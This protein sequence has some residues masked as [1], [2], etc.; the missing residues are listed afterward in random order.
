MTPR[1][2]V[3]LPT[4]NRAS[5][6]EGAVA[7][8]LASDL[9]LE[10]IVLDN[11]S[12]DGTW[13]FLQDLAR[14]DRRLRPI[15]WDGNN[16]YEAYAWPL[17]QARG[18]FVN[19]FADDDEMLP[20]G[21]AR[22]LELLER[23]PDLGMVFSTVACMDV[24]GKDLGEGAWTRIGPE[25]ALDRRDLFQS[26]VLGNFVAMPTAMF[27]RSLAPGADLFRDRSFFASNDW[28]FWLD[29]VQRTRVA[30]LSAPTARL[31]LH[32]G[33][34]TITHGIN[35]GHFME[36][37]LRVWRYWMLEHDPPFI[38]TAGTW[39]AMCRIM[40]GAMQASLGQDQDRI[41]AGFRRLQALRDEQD[42][43]L[44][45]AQ[46]LQEAGQAEAF[47][48][49]PDWLAGDWQGVVK[50]YLEAFTPE[51]PVALFLVLDP[52]AAGAPEEDQAGRALA[53]V[54]AEAG[55]DW[56]PEVRVVGPDR[57]FEAVRAFPHLQWLRRRTLEGVKGKRLSACLPGRVQ[58]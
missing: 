27:R 8:V 44:G 9:D 53:Q 2:S 17:E 41:Q 54:V 39:S 3:L 50:G 23:T 58:P 32:A 21:L 28:Q 34:V 5:M 18:E 14:R 36:A 7:S 11:G 46:D 49:E 51:D 12:Q 6:L 35:Q 4:F 19:F 56:V 15:H 57:V 22:K 38:P 31:R 25:D 45:R 40:A 33:Q 1:L 43:K 55:R 10:L 42:D 37:N 16:G 52:A 13:P 48:L 30:F 24:D 20:G 26:L 29:L 47:L